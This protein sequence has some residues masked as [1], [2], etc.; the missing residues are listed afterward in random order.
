[1]ST[2]TKLKDSQQI[3]FIRKLKNQVHGAITFFIIEKSKRNYFW[4]ST[5]FCNKNGNGKDCKSVKQ[6]WK[7]TFKIF[8][9]KK[10]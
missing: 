8:I 2:Q 4:I 10:S 9:K 1:M 3:N 6:V 7:W 5:K